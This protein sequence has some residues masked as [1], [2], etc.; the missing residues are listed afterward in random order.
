[1][2]FVT[3]AAVV[4][5]A[6]SAYGVYNAAT[7]SGPKAPASRNISS[8]LTAILQQYPGLQSLLT[9]GSGN[10]NQ[11]ALS[12]LSTLTG[13]GAPTFNAAAA[14]ASM[15]PTD[16]A[17]IEKEAASVGVSAEQWLA[18]H[19]QDEAAKGDP[20]S[21]AYL[22]TY[23]Q[24]PTGVGQQGNN[25]NTA[26]RQSNL[27]DVSNLS[28][29]YN[30]I[31]KGS[32]QDYYKQLGTFTDA[33]NAPVQ[34][35][36]QQQQQSAMASSGFGS[37]DP[38]GLYASPSQVNV[39]TVTPQTVNAQQI[40]QQQINPLLS[41]LTGQAM[42]NQGPSINQQAQNAY[43]LQAI[44]NGGNLS[45]SELRDVQ[46]S[47]RA[48]FASRG[49]GATNASV[50]DEA[51]QTDSAKR[52][53]LL[54]NLGLA[55]G[56]QNQGLAEQNQQQQFGL[57][58]GSQ[59][60]GYNQLGQQ[61]NLANQSSDLQGQ[62]ANQSSN[63]SGQL[64]NQSTGLQASLANQS[65]GLQAQLANQSFGLNSFNANLNSQQAQQNALLQSAQLQEQQ[66]QAQL[67]AQQAAV[68]AQATGRVDPYA[69]I[70]GGTNDQL[71]SLLSLYGQGQSSQSNILNALLG[72]GQDVNNTNYNANAAANIA[73]YNGQQSLN[74]SLIGAGTNLLSSYLGGRTGQSNSIG[75]VTASAL[76]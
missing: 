44:S 6:A 10:F 59:L 73:G 7:A 66:R 12:G 2:S 49:L 14:L 52:A 32:N 27:N 31:I 8:E 23:T 46:Q 4:G 68:Q 29:Q 26:N 22:N 64:A 41:Q 25:L 38:S 13:G 76:Y 55:Q 34:Q 58:V 56:V 19:V 1:M 65:A 57:G 62:L 20:V 16:R 47:S 74:G 42:Q 60:F 53:R 24:T 61:A 36:A 37:F 50:V 45:N 5:T 21:I 40:G 18:G 51:L 71:G 43:A 35:S 33:A 28:K 54:Q 72:Y 69:A 39:Q 15:S 75:T 17:G 70:L 3:T 11:S 30:D 48:G 67:A 63:L 9:G